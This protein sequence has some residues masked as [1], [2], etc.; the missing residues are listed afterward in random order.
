MAI[1]VDDSFLALLE[2]VQVLF[3]HRLL[4]LHK[5]SM[6]AVLFTET[7]IM[8][9]RYRRIILVLRYLQYLLKLPA[10]HYA[11]AAFNDA[12]LLH[13]E[14]KPS[15]VGD[16]VFVL[17]HLQISVMLKPVHLANPDSIMDL[18]ADVELSCAC[19]LQKDINES[20]KTVLLKKRILTSCP[21]EL[22]DVLKYW[23][24]L[25]VA[26]PAHCKVLTQLVTSCHMLAVNSLWWDPVQ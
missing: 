3:L 14:K 15:W 10:H 12:C 13:A 16:I 4:G 23:H 17:S 21:L 20:E 24:Y 26:V 11:H 6:H 19:A 8:P 7:G 18:I 9:I 2:D 22:S 5:K 25:D 1:D